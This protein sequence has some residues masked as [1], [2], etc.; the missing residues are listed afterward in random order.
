MNEVLVIVKNNDLY[1]GT[2]KL[3]ISFKIEH[4]SIKIL[5]DKFKKEFEE[6]GEG[7]ILSQNMVAISSFKMT[8]LSSEK[9]GRPTIE[10]LLNEPQATYLLTLIRNNDIVRKFKMHLTKEFFRQRSLLNQIAV[11]RQN[12]EWLEARETGKIERRF[13]TDTIQE[14]VQ[15][16]TEQG[17]KSA[18]KYYMIITKMENHTLFALDFLNQKFTNLRD[19]VNRKGLDLL[20][21][22]DKIV[23]KALRDGMKDQ[24][25]YK[26][27]YQM[28]KSRIESFVDLV[29]KTPLVEVLPENPLVELK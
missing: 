8:K 1:V 5:V 21:T 18:E 28:A 19:M 3:S 23:A 12:K 13:E 2:H 7:K 16:A 11:Q 17:S 25:F 10:Y 9:R 6:L 22:A 15:Y 27:I 14:F 24:M 4:R 20:K 29:G 26:D